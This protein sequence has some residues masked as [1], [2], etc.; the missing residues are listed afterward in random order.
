MKR[1]AGAGVINDEL[2]VDWLSARAKREART[3]I[4]G[5]F[6]VEMRLAHR[7]AKGRLGFRE[8]SCGDK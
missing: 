5:N 2:R 3:A 7:C 8:S 4:A 1:S 6:A